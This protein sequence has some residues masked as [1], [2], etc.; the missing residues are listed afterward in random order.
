MV[1]Y[2][3][4][5][6]GPQGRVGAELSKYQNR[7]KAWIDSAGDMVIKKVS[8]GKEMILNHKSIELPAMN[9]TALVQF[10]NVDHRLIFQFGP[11]ELTYDLGR[12]PEDAG[13][14]ETE[15]QPQV[16]IFG[17]GRLRLSHVAILRDIHYI[18]GK[19]ANN[20]KTARAMEGN[21]FKLVKDEFFMLGDNSPNSEDGRWWG[22]QGI[23]NNGQFYRAG[24]VPRDY[25]VGKALF[26]YW[27]SGFRPF[28]QSRFACIPNVGLM[29]FIYGGSPR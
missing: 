23:G 2:Y 11:E 14:R 5:S 6:T 4:H 20:A 18:A 12:G 19:F 10:A 15:I 16:K 9:K 26:V 27:P 24:I 8:A 17:S 28:A 25:L 7:Y 3:A 29:R 13:P 22:R 21:P 1:R